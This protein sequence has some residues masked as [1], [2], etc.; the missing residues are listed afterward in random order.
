M[1]SICWNIGSVAAKFDP[2]R[3][4]EGL[5]FTHHAEERPFVGDWR[6]R[7]HLFALA[8]LQIMWRNCGCPYPSVVTLIPVRLKPRAVPSAR[9]FSLWAIAGW[10]RSAAGRAVPTVTRRLSSRV[11]GQLTA[12]LN[13]GMPKPEHAFS[14]GQQVYHHHGPGGTPTGPYTVIGLLWQTGSAMRYCIR[15]TVREQIV[16]ESDLQLASSR[17]DAGE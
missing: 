16:D 1:G 7:C 3:R 9:G 10:S 4:H 13:I 17:E 12:D 8:H 6:A 5:T 2:S 14:I 11:C 15:S